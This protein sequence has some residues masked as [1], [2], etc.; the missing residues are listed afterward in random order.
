MKPPSRSW[1]NIATEKMN[2]KLMKPSYVELDRYIFGNTEVIESFFDQHG[3]FINSFHPAL[4]FGADE[5]MLEPSVNKKICVPDDVARIIKSGIPNMPHITAL[6]GHN[7]TGQALPLFVVLKELR[8][9]PDE[10]HDF[11]ATGQAWFGSSPSGFMTR[12]LF[13]Q[14][15]IHFINWLSMFRLT[16]D[17]EV[18]NK[19]ALLIIQ[20]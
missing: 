20:Y 1:V 5:T 7:I 18:R 9:L 17:T 2:A 13:L 6:C 15:A 16:L 11:A 10:L 12:D 19:K 8:R 3:D 14:W 4:V